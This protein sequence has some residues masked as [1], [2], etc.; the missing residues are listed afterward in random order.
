MAKDVGRSVDYL[1]TRPDIDTGQLA[2]YGVS[3]GASV[4]PL[5]LAIEH[6]FKARRPAGRRVRLL[7]TC[8]PRW[9]PSTSRRA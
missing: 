5:F 3:L 4:A 7:A 6:R 2:F 8:L 9:I 1:E